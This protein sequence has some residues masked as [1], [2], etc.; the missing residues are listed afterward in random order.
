MT[1]SDGDLA[2]RPSGRELRL[3]PLSWLFITAA[4]TKG[5]IG[6][7][8]LLA[9]FSG[10]SHLELLSILLVFPALV[11]ALLR[12]G[13][14]RYRLGSDEIV[15][16][17]GILTRNERHIPY[18]RVQNVDLVRNPF[19]RL[20]GVA[21]VRLETAGGQRPE[22]VLRVLSMEA[23]Q[24]MQRR[25]SAGAEVREVDQEETEPL[26]DLS[27]VELV[28]LGLISNRGMLVLA[29]L[30][31]LFWQA[32]GFDQRLEQ[33][34]PEIFGQLSTT[35]EGLS[36]WW[37]VPG[38]L[39]LL[40]LLRLFSVVWYLFQLRG[41]QLWLEQRELRAEYGLLNQIA[42]TVPLR[43][44]QLISCH[45]SPLHRF[46]GRVSVRLETAG[47]VGDE[48]D[49]N[50]SGSR[51][52]A[53][54]LAPV[55]PT[56][57]LP[58]LLQAVQSEIDLRSL[59][60]RSLAP[61]AQVRLTR[62]GVLAAIAVGLALVPTLGVWSLLVP[63]LGVPWAFLHAKLYVRYT[64]YALSDWGVAFRSGWWNRRMSLVRFAKCQNV[65]TSSSPF[66]RRHDMASLRADTAGAGKLKH[67]V[68]IPYLNRKDARSLQQQIYQ[69]A[70]RRHFAW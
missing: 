20:F 41:F 57:R 18:A 47:G 48:G 58:E 31:G 27:D 16:R 14:F 54:W 21:L 7:W 28:K 68:D 60:W 2:N 4:S 24:Q 11:R 17:D 29:A 30:A 42:A 49:H 62:K 69:E 67:A 59:E 43:R 26:L 34:S 10:G 63:V 40:I 61:R 65:Q 55:L 15:I 19:H 66:D 64:G 38:L 56:S 39:A 44:I 33:F 12:Y 13:V 51:S 37:F 53:P 5:L 32:G 23:V 25:V 50:D 6:P 9:L 3:H 1:V 22:A 36:F 52:E 46:F 35:V 45:E 70:G 8:V